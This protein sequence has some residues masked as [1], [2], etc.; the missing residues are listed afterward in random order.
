MLANGLIKALAITNGCPSSHE[1]LSN[2]ELS[3]KLPLLD[4][5]KAAETKACIKN[6][7]TCA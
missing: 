4:P 7:D 3:C 2:K 5:F 1:G 6:R